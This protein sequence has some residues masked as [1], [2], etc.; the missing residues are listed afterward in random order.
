MSPLNAVL[1]VNELCKGDTIWVL[2]YPI[3]ELGSYDVFIDSFPCGTLLHVHLNE[4]FVDTS[5][6]IVGNTLETNEPA[7]IVQWYD[8]V[9]NLPIPGA[10][11][12]TFT[13]SVSG[14]YKAKF[15][16]LSGCDAFTGCRTIILTRIDNTP[17]LIAW[18]IFPNP[19]HDFLDI[20]VDQQL[21]QDLHLEI[22]NTLGQQQMEQTLLTTINNRI[23]LKSLPSGS[24]MIRLS[25]EKGNASTKLFSKI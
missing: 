5:I 23:D 9:A 3:T 4:I 20:S 17:E 21:K 19:A 24:F 11:G 2:G 12:R 18:H 7:I 15:T 22:L 1:T 14:T 10:I 16:S 13:P 8:C 25:D 6:T